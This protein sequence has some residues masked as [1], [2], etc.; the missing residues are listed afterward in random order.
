[1]IVYVITNNYK[2]IINI[3]SNRE[4][5]ENYILTHSNVTDFDLKNIGVSTAREFFE[6]FGW[7]DDCMGFNL[8]EYEVL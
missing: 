8:Y 5:A 4:D 1:M 2:N 7:G 6:F 3:Y